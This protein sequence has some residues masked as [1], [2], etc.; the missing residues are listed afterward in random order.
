M[1]TFHPEMLN[2]EIDYISFYYIHSNIINEKIFLFFL[3]FNNSCFVKFVSMI[4]A[5]KHLS[6]A[7]DSKLEKIEYEL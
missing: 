5:C 6:N 1:N 4:S 2:S 3:K 7:R